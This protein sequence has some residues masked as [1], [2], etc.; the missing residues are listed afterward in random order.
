MKAPDYFREQFRENTQLRTS[1]LAYLD[2]YRDSIV[3]E[4]VSID[5][6]HELYRKQGFVRGLERLSVH[7]KKE[8]GSGATN[9]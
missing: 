5:A 9:K 2:E 1:L 6:E 8:V 3:K 4:M 7:L